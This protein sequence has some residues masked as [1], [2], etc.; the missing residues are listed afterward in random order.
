VTTEDE[1]PPP[2]VRDLLAAHAAARERTAGE[3]MFTV[4]S[5]NGARLG[6]F[7][8]QLFTAPG[9]RPVAVATQGPAEGGRL[10]DGAEDYAAEAWCRHF[11]GSAEPPV[12]ITLQLRPGPPDGPPEQVAWTL[13]L[14]RPQGMNR[15][16]FTTAPPWWRRLARQAIP[17]RAPRD[18]CYYHSV[19]WHQ[20]SAAATGA[21]RQARREGTAGWALSSRV[22]EL[23]AAQNLPAQEKEALGELLAERTAIQPTR[24]IRRRPCYGNGRHRITAMFD[25]GVRRTAVLRWRYPG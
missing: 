16:C 1:D 14:P 20:V 11:P 10:A 9:T 7:R 17:R 23:V 8:L 15:G 21:I 5:W 6:T 19:D 12:W 4:R 22:A 24:L 18:C 25:S 13:L 3:H 2:A